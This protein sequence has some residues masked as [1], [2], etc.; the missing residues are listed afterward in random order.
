MKQLVV[1][2]A[3][4]LLV[5]ACQAGDSGPKTKPPKIDEARVTSVEVKGRAMYEFSGRVDPKGN[6]VVAT[7]VFYATGDTP[8]TK[9]ADGVTLNG[10][11]T[12]EAEYLPAQR[13]F[14]Y[15][16]ASDNNTALESYFNDSEEGK[17][18]FY[19]EIDYKAPDYEETFTEKSNVFTCDGDDIERKNLA[20]EV[21]N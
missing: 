13:Q 3:C 12:R 15:I 16:S 10:A 21:K 4:V 14:R 9:G 11:E 8:Y 5:A 20:T 2:L 1:S 19:F 18:A 7:R 17:T 6:K